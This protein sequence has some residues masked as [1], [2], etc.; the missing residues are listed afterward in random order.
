M[1]R[2]RLVRDRFRGAVTFGRR[3]FVS[4]S[5]RR[6]LVRDFRGLVFD[7]HGRCLGRM[8]TSRIVLRLV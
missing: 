3:F 7:V 6:S 1:S 8:M 5:V 4:L 2:V